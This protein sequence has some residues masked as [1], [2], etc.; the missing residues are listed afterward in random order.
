MATHRAGPAR[1]LVRIDAGSH[2]FPDTV[3]EVVAHS[4]DQ[5]IAVTVTTTSAG[6][7]AAHLEQR[8]EPAD[9]RVADGSIGGARP[10]RH[11]VERVRGE[12]TGVGAVLNTARIEPGSSVAVF[13][14]GHPR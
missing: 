10:E 14:C 6:G 4:D 3:F 7:G 11:D 8:D 2:W 9:E 13:G 5:F 1:E 12:T